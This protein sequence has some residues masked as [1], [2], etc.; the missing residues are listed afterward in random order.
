MN[1]FG[2]YPVTV[3]VCANYDIYSALTK[4]NDQP[5]QKP[6]P[7]THN[8]TRN[9]ETDVHSNAAKTQTNHQNPT[10]QRIKHRVCRN[11]LKTFMLK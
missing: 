9:V 7:M 2:K 8:Q 1:S 11:D 10:G 6:L 5:N 4:E 3:H